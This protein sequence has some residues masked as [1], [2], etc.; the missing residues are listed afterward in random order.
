[1][2]SG[3]AVQRGRLWSEDCS[4]RRC[5]RPAPPHPPRRRRNTGWRYRPIRGR[6]H[7][8]ASG[9][10]PASLLRRIWMLAIEPLLRR[11]HGGADTSSGRLSFC[12]VNGGRLVNVGMSCL[13]CAKTA[14]H[15]IE[16]VVLQNLYFRYGLL[17]IK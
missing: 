13:N 10:V 8:R 3:D 11:R 2:R 15:R 16:M 7:G 4:R 6:S 14:K 17:K 12:G 9:S 1:V 5:R